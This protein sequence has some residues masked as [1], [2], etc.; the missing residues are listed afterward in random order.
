MTG[1]STMARKMA[2]GKNT[3]WFETF[4]VNDIRF[5]LDANTLLIVFDELSTVSQLSYIKQISKQKSIKFRMPYQAKQTV[6]TTP[7]IIAISN[8]ISK[9]KAYKILK[10]NFE[11]I[12]L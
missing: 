3:V 4:P 1:K 5:D 8:S 9:E 10:D 6:I 12:E 11:Y 7:E 2:E